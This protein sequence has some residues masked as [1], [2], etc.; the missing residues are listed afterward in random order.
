MKISYNALIT[1]L[2]KASVLA[3][4]A[5]FSTWIFLF[6]G[7]MLVPDIGWFVPIDATINGITIYLMFKFSETPYLFLCKP[8]ALLCYL[9]F[10]GW[11]A[12]K[13]ATK[14]ERFLAVGSTTT[15][16]SV[17]SMESDH[18]ADFASN[19]T[20]ENAADL[21]QANISIQKSVSSQQDVDSI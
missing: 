15:D 5:V 19:A 4:V 20:R 8:M 11:D 6:V 3:S 18:K 9:C 1:Q 21:V 14:D 12:A 17:G 13:E 16:V 7:M 2:V 10:A